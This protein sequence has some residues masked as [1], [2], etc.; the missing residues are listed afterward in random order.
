MSI[1]GQRWLTR[2]M[3]PRAAF[4]EQ[5]PFWANLDSGLF[6]PMSSKEE[7]IGNDFEAYVSGAF[8][9]NGTV[10][11]CILA[12]QWVFS[13][14]RFQYRRF[15]SGRPQ[16][17]FGDSSLRAL[18]RPW[19]GGTTGEL[20]ARME[21]DASLAG[22]AFFTLADDAGRVGKAARGEGL[23]VAR[24][25]PDRVKLVIGSHSGNPN[26]I[27]A[28]VL[29]YWHKAPAGEGKD[30][31][32]TL[33]LAD[34]VAHYSPIPDPDAR[35][36]GMSW[37]TPLIKEIEADKLA[38][39]HKGKF[40]NNAAVPNMAITF[41]KETAP[42]EF[43]EFVEAFRAKHQGAWNAYKTLFLMGGADVK[44]L[45]MNF[46]ELEFAQTQGKGESRIA[47][48]AGVPPSW[49]G[50]SE[51]LQGSSLNAGNFGAA[52]RRF[53][54]GTIRPLWRMAAASLER[55]LEVPEG[56]ELWYDDRDIAFLREDSKDQADI[57]STEAQSIRTLVDAGYK[58]ESI[59]AAITAA[60]W[61]LLEHTG[62]FSVQLQPPGGTGEEGASDG[63]AADPVPAGEG[64]APAKTGAAKQR[65]VAETIQKV[66]LGVG[67]VITAAEAREIANKA[68]ANL[69]LPGPF[70]DPDPEPEPEPEP[71]DPAEE[72]A[73]EPSEGDAPDEEDDEEQVS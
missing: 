7:I 28:H 16:A 66:Y 60:D 61:N 15:E 26:A 65:D 37:L 30:E 55:I 71:P 12:R 64:D 54:D 46:Q 70:P 47:A 45:S 29:G 39:V 24:L 72:P 40:F 25:R 34:E 1:L 14:A 35:F 19:P 22:N 36:V 21:Q 63:A 51:G 59:V 31:I 62:T 50:F 58:P 43:E 49:V 68:G 2:A 11:A 27:D 17:L 44:P 20:L 13:E 42:D 23:R 38:T 67:K 5:P 73:V 48:A 33:L 3:R 18:A 69:V 57:Q 10:F 9:A 41:D 8:K 52:R 6:A 56:A 4:P 53:A 32:K